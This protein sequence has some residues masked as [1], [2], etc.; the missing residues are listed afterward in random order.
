MRMK[1]AMCEKN[2]AC[3]KKKERTK[4]KWENA[5]KSRRA[6]NAVYGESTAHRQPDYLSICIVFVLSIF[7]YFFIWWSVTL[8]ISVAFVHI[9]ETFPL[10]CSPEMLNKSLLKL[11]YKNYPKKFPAGKMQQ[12]NLQQP[13]IVATKNH[14][15]QRLQ[16]YKNGHCCCVWYSSHSTAEMCV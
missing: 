9:Q 13:A 5:T 4:D 15:R 3:M 16:R 12:L 11:K 10:D 14:R 2:S 7:F 6:P 1:N 8:P